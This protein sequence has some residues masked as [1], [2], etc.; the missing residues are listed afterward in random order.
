MD[1]LAVTVMK[2][3]SK[4]TDIYHLFERAYNQQHFEEQGLLELEGDRLIEKS[5]ASD[6]WTKFTIM[7]SAN[8]THNR[9][10]GYQ[11]VLANDYTVQIWQERY[12][13]FDTPM[14]NG[15]LYFL[16]LYNPEDKI[17]AGALAN[18]NGIYF[19]YDNENPECRNSDEDLA[20]LKGAVHAVVGA[21]ITIARCTSPLTWSEFVKINQLG[22]DDERMCQTLEL[23]TS[24]EEKNDLNKLKLEL[25]I[26]FGSHTLKWSLF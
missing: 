25:E 6:G 13:A 1:N 8:P 15:Y 23:K 11:K 17:I 5:F 4:M 24:N 26:Q 21:V 14:Q 3:F 7:R 10:N 2:D 22:K 18:L 20:V 9:V 16:F 19:A 12:S